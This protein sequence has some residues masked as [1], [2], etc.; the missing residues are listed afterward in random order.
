VT[1]S[2]D[3]IGEAGS[4]GVLLLDPQLG[5]VIK[6]AIEHMRCIANGGVDDF[7]KTVE[8]D[9][10]KARHV[11]HG[12]AVDGQRAVYAQR[13]LTSY[14]SSVQEKVAAEKAHSQSVGRLVP[15]KSVE[16]APTKAQLEKL[17]TPAM[18][19][20]SQDRTLSLSQGLRL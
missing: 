10:A 4:I 8:L 16:P 20:P 6:E 3:V 19:A 14:L 18:P 5:L 11:E 2:K 17:S 1:E 13:V 9:P 12:Y 15:D 7:G